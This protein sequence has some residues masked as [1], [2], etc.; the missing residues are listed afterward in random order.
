MVDNSDL[1]AAEAKL[2]AAYTFAYIA[3][4]PLEPRA[5][6]AEWKGDKLTVWTG[7]QRPFGG[8]VTNWR[9]L[10][11]SRGSRACDRSG[12]RFGLRRQAHRR[13][14]RRS[15]ASREGRRQA[16]QV[17]WTR[18]EEFTWAYF[19]PAGVI[20]SQ[21][22][23]SDGLITA[24]EFHNYNSGPRPSKRP[25]TFPTSSIQFHPPT[26]PLRQG[27]YRGTGRHRQP[28]RARIAHERLAT[29][30]STDPLELRLKHTRT[31]SA[32]AR[33]SK[34][35]RTSLA[36]TGDSGTAGRGSGIAGGFEK[37]GYI[38][39]C[40][41]KSRIDPASWE[42]AQTRVVAAFECGAVVNPNGLQN[43]VSGAIVQG[44]GG[45][46]FE[47]IKFENGKILTRT[48]VNIAFHAFPTCPRLRLC[49]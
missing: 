4:V 6:V 1:Q 34:R 29:E 9:R 8:H 36:G 16:G 11:S 48:S 39:M 28:L 38:A 44:I 46:L 20:E 27:S 23:T 43:Q 3:H 35:Q 31:P 26:S 41:L 33:C 15:S 42:G 49:S 19:R 21:R 25:T 7:T 2:E 22:R 47:T 12:H 32:C 5:A 17:V 10:S 45:A 37:L 18:E 14:G 40:V 24:W 13:G 30:L